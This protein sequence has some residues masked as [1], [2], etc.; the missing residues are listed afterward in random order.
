MSARINQ[1]AAVAALAFV[2]GISGCR[3]GQGLQPGGF[4]QPGVVTGRPAF[5]R[6][7]GH[8]AG[9]IALNRLI[10]AGITQAVSGF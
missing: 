4:Q 1:F 9:N 5:G 8:R 2:V 7:I 10:N 6:K 3:A